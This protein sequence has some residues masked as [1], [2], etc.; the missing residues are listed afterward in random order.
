MIF[1]LL[2]TGVILW[3]ACDVIIEQDKQRQRAALK[4]MH[5]Q[6]LKATRR[7]DA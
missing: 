6:C 2:L 1:W 4:S 3:I 5:E 7:D